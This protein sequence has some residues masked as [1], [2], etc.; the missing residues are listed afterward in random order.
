MSKTKDNKDLTREQKVDRVYLLLCR[1]LDRA[2]ILEYA[3]DPDN[4]WKDKETA[5]D[6]F[7]T[8]AETKLA[9]EA[10]NIDPQAEAGKAIARLNHLYQ[11][12][13]KCQDHKTALSIQ[14][15]INKMLALTL[16]GTPAS[17]PATQPA[18]TP[19]RIRLVK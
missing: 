4:A 5:I 16:R 17:K 18:A 10:A 3:R 9:D 1:G 2:S 8:E 11:E 19:N 14:K 12:A 13:I 6:E 15:E 7:I